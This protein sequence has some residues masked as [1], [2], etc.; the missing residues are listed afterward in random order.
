M[1]IPTQI[2]S[3]GTS[4]AAQ[5]EAN[6]LPNA[7]THTD[8]VRS[9]ILGENPHAE[10][11]LMSATLAHAEQYCPGISSRITLADGLA[12]IQGLLKTIRSVT[13][14]GIGIMDSKPLPHLKLG[15]P[16]T[17]W[18]SIVD[19]LKNTSERR[20]DNPWDSRVVGGRSTKSRAPVEKKRAAKTSGK[21]TTKSH[22]P[23]TPAQPAVRIK[24]Q[25]AAALRGV[26]I[27]KSSLMGA[28]RKLADKAKRALRSRGWSSIASRMEV[29]ITEKAIN[30]RVFGLNQTQFDALDTNLPPLRRLGFITEDDITKAGAQSWASTVD[31]HEEVQ[32]LVTIAQNKKIRAERMKASREELPPKL[33]FLSGKPITDRRLFAEALRD[34]FSLSLG[35]SKGVTFVTLS[36]SSDADGVWKIGITVKLGDLRRRLAAYACL[37]KDGELLWSAK[38]DDLYDEVQ[39]APIV[40]EKDVILVKQLPKAVTVLGAFGGDTTMSSRV[41]SS[42]KTTDKGE[43]QKAPSPTLPTAKSSGGAAPAG[44]AKDGQRRKSFGRGTPSRVQ[45][46]PSPLATEHIGRGGRGPKV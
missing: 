38:R 44:A 34:A 19:A 21:G 4:V 43:K 29:P 8:G 10:L 17:T 45:Q 31:D 24:P 11:S 32:K 39:L 22:L 2:T 28:Q 41:L 14:G 7:S 40:K 15:P 18:S 16:T 13:P 12:L 23:L 20:T 1:S 30:K 42:P 35:T 3:G 37:G 33:Q 6:K 26:A 9:T 27:E 25:A 5:E 46:T 36:E